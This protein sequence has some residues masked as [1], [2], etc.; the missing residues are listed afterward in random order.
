MLHFWLSVFIKTF[1]DSVG[2]VG[3]TKTGLLFI[4]L[5]L[6]VTC[7][8]LLKRHGWREAAKH[9][10]RSSG[11]GV[12]ITITA[13]I[14]VS[15]IHFIYEPY[16]LFNDEQA[17]RN[18][19]NRQLDTA[20]YRSLMCE[21]NLKAA[22]GKIEL[23]SSQVASQQTLIASQQT[24][25][26]SQQSTFNLCVAT[27]SKIN[28]P[29]PQKMTMDMLGDDPDAAPIAKHRM[30]V[31]LITN[32]VVSPARFLFSCEGDIKLLRG[33]PAN[34]SSFGGGS[35]KLRDGRWLTVITFPAWSPENP[36]LLRVDYDENN[37]GSCNVTPQ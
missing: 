11:E 36:I 19:A 35:V 12:A 5:V 34:G 33:V 18:E 3:Q 32:A 20:E 21:G 31:L 25:A 13:F 17:R 10:M 24:T 23:L 26:N 29:V 1:W 8:L 27:L 30:I 14:L 4:G 22:D 2:F 7:V 28:A 37:I 9:W 6:V 15:G 16:H